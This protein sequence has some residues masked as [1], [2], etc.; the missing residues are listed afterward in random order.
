MA[1]QLAPFRP[2][3]RQRM[4]TVGSIPISGGSSASLTFP[5]VGLL[6]RIFL[7]CNATVS[8]AAASPSVAASAFGP[9]NLLKR[10]T[11]VTNLGTATVFDVSGYNLFAMST[12]FDT[13]FKLNAANS[14]V[15]SDPFYQYPTSGFVQNTPKAVTFCLV[16]PVT[17]NDEDQFSIGLINLQ[18]PELRFT[19][20]VQFSGTPGAASGS[21]SDVYTTSDTLTLGGNLYVYYEYYEVPNPSAVALPQRI[22]HR[23]LED[24][25]P[26]T[27]GGDQLYTVARQGILLQLLHTCVLNG[28]ID[29]TAS[30]Y[31]GRRLV[32]NKTD[33]PYRFDYIV[34]R[35]L[36]RLRYGYSGA[37]TDLPGGSFLWDFFRTASGAPSAGDLR[38]AIDSEALSTLES[39]VT[40]T[41]SPTLGSG[42]NFLQSIRRITQQY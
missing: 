32:F 14:D 38:D 11:G 1:Q 6:A 33:T 20:Q 2:N 9:W 25:Q 40:L 35:I 29:K 16:I 12:A 21:I 27:A 24:S 4:Q 10:L 3:T 37:D 22:M 34:D 36:N 39:Y 41:G 15:S 28:T 7:F 13:A 5:Q 26:I 8:D 23:L 31:V 19:L 17:A 18:A 42:T 30:D